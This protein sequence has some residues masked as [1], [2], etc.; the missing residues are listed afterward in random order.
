MFGKLR[1]WLFGLVTRVPPDVAA[2]EFD[3]HTTECHFGDWRNC[4]RRMET[5]QREQQDAAADD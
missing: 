3:C 5:L 4:P 2:C 1:D